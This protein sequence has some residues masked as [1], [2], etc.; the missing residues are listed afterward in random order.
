MKASGDRYHDHER[1]H[2]VEQWMGS[3]VSTV[4]CHW[5]SSFRF[6]SQGLPFTMS[7]VFAELFI[8]LQG[9]Q[10]TYGTAFLRNEIQVYDSWSRLNGNY[11]VKNLTEVHVN[12]LPIIII[13][14]VME[15]KDTWTLVFIRPCCLKSSLILT[16]A[17]CQ[18]SN[19]CSIPIR[20]VE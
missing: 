14:G 10:M 16:Y 18:L 6:I 7:N 11:F 13:H 5:I 20:T 12:K 19:I 1:H 8:R 3:W 2:R 15:I 4:E 17:S 9:L